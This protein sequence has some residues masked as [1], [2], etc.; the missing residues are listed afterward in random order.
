VS[1]DLSPDEKRIVNRA[2][3]ALRPIVDGGCPAVLPNARSAVD[4]F[5]EMLEQYGDASLPAEGSLRGVRRRDPI[6]HRGR[7]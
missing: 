7:R 1:R 4:V 2:L 6:R 5:I 3:G